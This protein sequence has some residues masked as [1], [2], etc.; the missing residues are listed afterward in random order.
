MYCRSDSKERRTDW[1][2]DEKIQVAKENEEK[3]ERS[4][5][6]LINI[7]GGFILLFFI[8]TLLITISYGEEK[9]Q[10]F[11][12]GTIK[13]EIKK[14]YK[15]RK[16][17]IKGLK[18]ISPEIIKPII[19]FGNGAVVTRDTI[20]NTIRDLYKLGYFR[21][22]ET[23]TRYTENGVDIIFVFKELPVVQKIEFEGNEE[24]PSEDLL[25]ELGIQIQERQET[26]AALPF[27]TVGPELTEKLS[28]IKR[29]LGRVLSVD[30]IN[31]MVKSI[32]KKYEKEGFYNVKVSY[33]F[34]GNILVFKIDEGERAYVKKII[35]EGN[36]QIEED[37]IL[38]VMET[39]QRNPWKLRFHPRLQKDVLYEDVEKIRDLYINKGFFDVS[40]SEPEIQLKNKEEYYIT[41]RIKEGDRYKLEGIEFVNNTLYTEDEL[42]EKFQKDLKIGDYYNGEI[43]NK[44]KMET[45]D[46]YSELGFLF[47]NVYIKKIIDRNK[48]V[49]KVVFEIDK[50]NIFYV[51]LIDIKG[52]YESRDYVIRRELRFAPGDLFLRKDI[53]R[54]QSRLYRLGFYNMVGFDP[55][56]KEE[57][58][59]DVGVN[60]S[61]RFTGQMSIGAGYSQLTGFSLFASIK[62]G[63]FL[64]TGDTLGLSLSIGSQYRNN[65][66]SYLHRWAFYKPLD[67]GFSIYERYVD[68]TTFKSTK[69]GF[70]PTLSYEISEYWRTGIGITV[71]KGKYSDIDENA[72]LRIREQEGKYE[73]YSIYNYYNRNSVDNPLLPTRGSDFNITFKVG[74]GT[75]GF[76]KLSTSYAF[77]LPDKLLYTNWVFSF[78]V[79]YG[80]VKEMGDKLPLDELFFVG[81]DFSIRGFDYGMAG[82]YDVNLDPSGAKQ[83]LVFNYQ[84][85]HPLVERFLWGYFFLDQGKGYN[86]G[87]P[88]KNMYYSVGAGLK[89]VTPVAPIDIYY[90]KVL[91]AP[92]G[93]SDSRLGFVLGT[94]F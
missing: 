10:N 15:I 73:L 5:N 42:L 1:Y 21:E 76:Y 14:I 13:E 48:K 91:N 93:V 8:L 94:F 17:E 84:L 65:E 44:I 86:G 82:P 74:F 67:L 50:G 77:F 66:L 23:Y 26:G 59:M 6:N 83:Q 72:P 25:Q 30:E 56:V 11:S 2:K 24:I 60:V 79:R 58:V 40:I 88:F 31:R 92:E 54:S 68:Y 75:R 71:E 55:R 49:V 81:G 28:S 47:S 22:V 78:K 62:K 89:I 85:A 18:Y 53:M 34:K 52:N 16:I 43:I 29:G 27:S 4:G 9:D 70:S 63:N 12:P 33:Y 37:E 61:E 57:G 51:D 36:H 3:R 35:I 64:G 80:V 45:V 20:S 7:K 41:I 87:N 39:K 38:D 19:P 90:G 32:E 46:K 69:V